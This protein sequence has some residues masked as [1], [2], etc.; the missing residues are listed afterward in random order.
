TDP[1]IYAATISGLHDINSAIFSPASRCCSDIRMRLA[2]SHQ[3]AGKRCKGPKP[4]SVRQARASQARDRRRQPTCSNRVNGLDGPASLRS[5]R[6][7]QK[8]RNTR[9]TK[10][11]KEDRLFCA[12]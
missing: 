12:F 9:S 7:E 5:E 10:G 4:R 11:A 3:E 6:A 1:K 8:G 2:H